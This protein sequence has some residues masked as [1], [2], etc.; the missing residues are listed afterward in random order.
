MTSGIDPYAVLAKYYDGAYAA[1]KDL[2]DVPFYV[3]LAKR[4]G[5]PRFS[6]LV[7]ARAACYLPPVRASPFTVSTVLSPC[8]AFLPEDRAG[9][10]GRARTDSHQ[11]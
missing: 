4:I 6:K 2:I 8:S 9:A 11:G 7:A 10:S 3:D 5:G 1:T